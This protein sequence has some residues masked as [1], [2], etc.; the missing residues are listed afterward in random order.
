[1]RLIPAIPTLFVLAGWS[2]LAG[3]EARTM[4]PPPTP[5]VPAAAPA[6]A[7]SDAQRAAILALYEQAVAAGFPDAKG[8]TLVIGALTVT[9][10]GSV[11]PRHRIKQHSSD[12]YSTTNSYDRAAHIRCADG[13]WL[14]HLSDPLTP[15]A[16]HR[17]TPEGTL[18]EATPAT[19][20]T[21]LAQDQTVSPPRLPPLADP[22]LAVFTA[23]ERARLLACLEIIRPLAEVNHPISALHLLRL[24]VV[25]A[26]ALLLATVAASA[27][28]G[29]SLQP[30]SLTIPTRIGLSSAGRGRNQQPQQPYWQ[31]V[32]E[33]N[34]GRLSIPAPEAVVRQYFA[35]WFCNLLV[36]A[37]AFSAS[38]LTAARA[39][40]AT[41][42]FTSPDDRA[43]LRPILELLVAR[44]AIPA[45]AAAD[46]DLATRLQSW[47]SSLRFRRHAIDAATFARMPPKMQ[48]HFRGSGWQ[49][50]EADVAALLDLLTDPRPSRWLDGRMPRT[51]G[52]NALRALQAVF[53]FDP[54][55]LVG[56]EIGA[57][58]TE[59][60]RLATAEA[61]RAWWSNLAGRPLAEGLTSAIG[62]LTPADM[63][64]L[65]NSRPL[66]ARPA[67]VDAIVQAWTAKPPLDQAPID[68]ASILAAAGDHAGLN[69]LVNTWKPEGSLRP[70]LACWH[71]RHGDPSVLDAILD[72]LLAAQPATK[73]AHTER[74]KHLSNILSLS[75]RSPSPARLQR[76]LA[77]ARGAP[78]DGRT[79][80]LLNAISLV[81]IPFDDD[82]TMII[83]A[84]NDNQ[85]RR[86]VAG[87]VRNAIPMA[88]AQVFLADQRVIPGS[89]LDVSRLGGGIMSD[90]TIAG[91][92]FSL[93]FAK[94]NP[95]PNS[96]PPQGLRVCDIA[97][98]TLL[99]TVHQYSLEDAGSLSQQR[100]DLWTTAEA[101]DQ[102]LQPL[103]EAFAEAARTALAA[104][105]LPAVVPPS[106][107]TGNQGG[108]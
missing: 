29:N 52:D 98:V 76:C 59:A 96:K 35:A 11:L 74:L 19:L 91:R 97:A 16:T 88:V 100:L 67:I 53:A 48:Q 93:E 13:R 62:G 63:V 92:R 103:I 85:H 10:P 80:A 2:I 101:R 61:L 25:Q 50:G 65:L 40:E 66:T 84:F 60:E 77:L 9:E 5:A 3:G 36:D 33:E 81:G 18:Q 21:I 22:I 86:L 57:P 70:L 73:E 43:A 71:D 24:G 79:W 23:P 26:D 64:I 54:R 14:L 106:A 32:L 78:E 87:D 1:M 45:T 105:K 15:D 69:A 42:S 17:V 46:A 107:P 75:M 41:L 104:A 6:P 58:W 4:P 39:A 89:V 30:Q 38:G 90:V 49:P 47:E 56:R 27:I 34:A 102:T 37:S 99:G 68:L 20:V 83:R 7:L 94:P 44:L 8:G 28:P 82:W 55:L 95:D 72:E 51:L 31:R 108:F 12:E